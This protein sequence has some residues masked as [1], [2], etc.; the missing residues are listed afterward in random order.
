MKKLPYIVRTFAC[1]IA[2]RMRRRASA[3]ANGRKHTESS[4]ATGRNACFL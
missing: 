1:R 3:R 2:F 4:N